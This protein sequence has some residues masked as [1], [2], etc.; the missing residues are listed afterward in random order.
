MLREALVSDTTNMIGDSTKGKGSEKCRHRLSDE[1]KRC[2][3]QKD[4][5]EV[6]R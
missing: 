1:Q 5:R 6:L 3:K 2:M 4:G